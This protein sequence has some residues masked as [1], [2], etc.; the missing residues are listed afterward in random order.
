MY[1]LIKDDVVVGI[2]PRVFDAPSFYTFAEAPEGCNIGWVV[3]DGV[4]VSPIDAMPASEREAL[5]LSQLREYRNRLLASTDYL[6]L[7]DNTLTPEMAAYR[8]ALRDITNT[9]TSI[10]DAVFP[11]KP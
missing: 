4:I 2:E 7:S 3:V 1:A 5:K 11:E 6:A 10:D 9:Y 8:Q